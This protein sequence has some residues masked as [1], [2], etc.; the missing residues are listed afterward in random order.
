MHQMPDMPAADTVE[1]EDEVWLC[2]N[3]TKATK[4]KRKGT[5]VYS[6]LAVKM[7]R[8]LSKRVRRNQ[9]RSS[10]VRLEIWIN[11]CFILS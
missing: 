5:Y 10:P 7:Y 9:S 2:Y 4:R 3:L 8:N 11:Q 1:A 6:L